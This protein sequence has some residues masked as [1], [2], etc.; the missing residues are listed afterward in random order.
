VAKSLSA[1]SKSVG[2]QELNIA[3]GE[4]SID[5]IKFTEFVNKMITA[6]PPSRIKELK[7]AALTR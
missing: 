4:I 5:E 1:I 3:P 2:A 6:D 7:A